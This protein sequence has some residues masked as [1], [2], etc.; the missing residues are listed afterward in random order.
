M[1][2][3]GRPSIGSRSLR[4]GNSRVDDLRDSLEESWS[5][6]CE[7]AK[8][9]AELIVSTSE[10]DFSGVALLDASGSARMVAACRH[11]TPSW[12]NLVVEPGDGLAS[13]VLKV[14]DLV[15]VQNY[16]SESGASSYLTRVVARDEQVT[17]MSAVPLQDQG[18]IF[19]FAYGILRRPEPISDSANQSLRNIASLLSAGILARGSTVAPVNI[20]QTE[21]SVGDRS[22]PDFHA[23]L[24]LSER[25]RKI[26][27]LLSEGLSTRDVA[28]TECLAVNTVRN[29]V[30]SA[31][32]KL[33]ANSRLQAIAI[34]R[35][36]NLI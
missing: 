4:T 11:Y 35:G 16:A 33:G 7:L 27:K 10:L 34:A 31:L 36:L 22:G 9:A 15:S 13:R 12:E 1:G 2:I 26:L 18:S 20:A 29:Y 28:A 30:Q 24:A 21:L 23:G 6:S 25:E 17:A 8:R 19:G 32:W 3:M 5:R 14:R